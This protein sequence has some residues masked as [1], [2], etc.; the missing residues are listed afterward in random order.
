MA[1]TASV[2]I[3]FDSQA[4]ADQGFLSAE[5]MKKTT[6]GKYVTGSQF[7][8]G[9]TAYIA[10][11]L[12]KNTTIQDKI[13]T[14]GTLTSAG[15]YT[16]DVI[17]GVT[18][19]TLDIEADDGKLNTASLTKPADSMPSLKFYGANVGAVTLGDDG[20]TLTAAQYGVAVAKA[21]YQSTAVMLALQ[22]PATLEDETTF[23]ITVVLIGS[24]V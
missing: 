13:T 17:D 1:V 8:P 7:K 15:S 24:L 21:T 2:T 4:A 5:V 18:F 16:A 20:R 3:K 12:G 9:D 6:D 14:A 11:Y 10:V 19:S 23:D 22:S